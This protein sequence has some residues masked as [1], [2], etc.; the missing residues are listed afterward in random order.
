MGGG[1]G[2]VRCAYPGRRSR[3]AG[4]T[5]SAPTAPA[6]CARMILTGCSSLTPPPMTPPPPGFMCLSEPSS[7]QWIRPLRSWPCSTRVPACGRRSSRPTS[8]PWISPVQ[9]HNAP[10]DKMSGTLRV[11]H[12]DDL[13]TWPGGAVLEDGWREPLL[14]AATH[15]LLS[16]HPHADEW[17]GTDRYDRRAWAGYLALALL[18]RHGLLDTVAPATWA[19]WAPAILWWWTVPSGTGDRKLKRDL[20]TRVAS[21]APDALV[22]P[23]LR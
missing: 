14:T 11:R 21:A 5:S 22:E 19:R 9:L 10:A 13:T 18:A 16:E 20:L 1:N 15:Y 4:M 17:L 7:P 8:R 6:C 23:A 12:D 2:S 3:Q